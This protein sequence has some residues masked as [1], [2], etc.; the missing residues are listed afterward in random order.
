MMQCTMLKKIIFSLLAFMIN[1]SIATSN[2]IGDNMNIQITIDGAKVSGQLNNTAAA[3]DLWGRLPITVTVYP[4]QSREVYSNI[5]LNTDGDK[6]ADSYNVGDIAYWTPGG[7]LVFYYGPG[8]T[9]SLVI[10]GRMTSDYGI[11]ADITRPIDV[12]I[13]RAQ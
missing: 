5:P 8:Y 10:M 7:A 4:H 9:D 6:I 3:R 2:T 13:E 1:I 11:L 12:T